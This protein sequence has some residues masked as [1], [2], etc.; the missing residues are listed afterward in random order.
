M[1]RQWKEIECIH[2]TINELFKNCD[3]IMKSVCVM[4]NQNMLEGGKIVEQRNIEVMEYMENGTVVSLIA[5]YGRL[6][7]NVARRLFKDIAQ[8]VEA[9][10]NRF[11]AHL[12]IKHINVLIN[13]NFQAV[14]ADFGFM[15]DATK[16]M[17]ILQGSE[18][19]RDPSLVQGE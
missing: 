4:K 3:H 8:A 17:N 19:W 9:M 1:E 11:L 6:P 2:E 18:H 16:T 5:R 7:E 12:D 13:K 15:N 14:L 10:H